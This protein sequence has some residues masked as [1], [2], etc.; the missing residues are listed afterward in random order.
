[1]LQQTQTAT[2]SN[3]IK[4]NSY[5]QNLKLKK[6]IRPSCNFK[7]FMLVIPGYFQSS[8]SLCENV[9]TT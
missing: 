3:Y 8:D 7:M 5:L 4:W 9:K 1:M 2:V 6:I